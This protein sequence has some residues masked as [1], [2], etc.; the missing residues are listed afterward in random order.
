MFNVRI[1]DD[2]DF[3]VSHGILVGMDN[4]EGQIDDCVNLEVMYGLAIKHKKVDMPEIST[5]NGLKNH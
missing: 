3:E 2:T 4:R 1:S 5:Y